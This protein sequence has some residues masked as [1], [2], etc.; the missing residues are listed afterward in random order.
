MTDITALLDTPRIKL[1]ARLEPI[2]GTRFQ[3]TGFPDLGPATYGSPV[4]GKRLLL[5]ESPQSMANWLEATLWDKASDTPT[6]PIRE[7][8]YVRVFDGNGEYLTSSRT[9]SHRLA[10]AYVKAADFAGVSGL[11]MIRERFGLEKQRPIDHSRVTRAV[12]DL[13]PLCLLHGSS[14]PTTSG[15]VSPRSPVRPRRSS[16]PRGCRRPTP[17]A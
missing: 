4:D 6:E 15:P 3:P 17:G 16:R 7:V 11:D 14:S 10:S 2:A 8:P 5:V 1:V 12:F 13:D 9:E